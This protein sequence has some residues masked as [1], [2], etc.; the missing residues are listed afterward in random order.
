MP[1]PPNLILLWTDE[2]RADTLA[3]YGNRRISMP[4][5][6]AFAG[7]ATVY[8]R[9]WC[10]QS[11]CTP[12]RASVMTGLMPHQHGVW[13]NNR[14]LAADQRTFAECLPGTYATGHF[15]KWHLGDE[16][17]AQHG[18]D[19][20]VASEDDYHT[21]YSP[22]R[23]RNARS[24]Y[25][26]FLVGQGYTPD[27]A[28]IFSRGFACG[29]PE[30]HSKPAFLADEAIRFIDRNAD[31]P[32]CLEVNC[33]EPH[34]PFTGCRN[35]Q[36][37]P[38][39]VDLP[40]TWRDHPGT[41]APWRT[42]ITA[43]VQQSR[44][45]N[46]FRITD[47]ASMRR[48]IANY[49]GLCSLVDHHYGRIFR[50]LERHGLWEDSLIIFTSDHGDQMGAHGLL[51]KCV[52]YEDCARIPMIAKFPGQRE[53][54]RVRAPVSQID[55]LPTILECAGVAVPDGLPGRSLRDHGRD[56]AFCEWNG[57]NG[58]CASEALVDEPRFPDGLGEDPA[59]LR[60]CWSAAARTIVT[61]DGWK[62]GR[63]EAGEAWLYDLNRD[64]GER[65]N[66]ARSEATRFEELSG[67]LRAWQRATGDA[68]VL[69]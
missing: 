69:G 34:M 46:G 35:E 41:D 40:D 51:A 26:H 5:L 11:V 47:E 39:D 12:A 56:A 28:G 30:A 54:T 15:G 62:L 19:T 58:V 32:F 18:F 36:Y 20:W 38:A 16:I 23:D 3:A 31:R 53:G 14:A 10:T 63:N 65:R 59:R 6:D 45:Q 52:H 13:P 17:F 37:D 2:Q 21:H 9:A 25:H 29:V 49:W 42:R 60:A 43:A 22:G 64:P 44:R 4:N 57:H 55:L 33:L 8:E 24:A 67:R 68:V 48:C 66:L 50:A 61:A 7:Q 1:R 27:E